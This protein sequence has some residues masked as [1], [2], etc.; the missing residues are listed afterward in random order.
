MRQIIAKQDE[1]DN[2][3]VKQIIFIAEYNSEGE[4]YNGLQYE[5]LCTKVQKLTTEIKDLKQQLAE[6]EFLDRDTDHAITGN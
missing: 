6:C 5:G 2:V 4:A 1:L 3:R